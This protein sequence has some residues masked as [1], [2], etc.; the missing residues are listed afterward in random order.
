MRNAGPAG[1]YGAAPGKL[2]ND[3]R[4]LI[5]NQRRSE[6]GCL[7]KYSK[8]NPKPLA[9][10]SNQSKRQAKKV[11]KANA[12]R[13]GVFCSVS[14]P[15]KTIN[16]VMVIEREGKIPQN[17]NKPRQWTK[18]PKP[19]QPN[20]QHRPQPTWTNENPIQGSAPQNHCN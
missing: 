14:C 8:L 16:F 19:S 1:L 13:I 18:T 6:E 7:L 5:I 15:W 20:I 12:R 4:K 2:I 10:E 3:S 11:I 9:A 17:Q